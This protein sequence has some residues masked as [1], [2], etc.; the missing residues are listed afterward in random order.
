MSDLQQKV[1]SKVSERKISE[2]EKSIEE[3]Q[4]KLTV[5]QNRLRTSENEAKKNVIFFQK[6]K[7]ETD[8]M[9]AIYSFLILF[10]SLET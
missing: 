9:K 2:Y 5:C 8:D 7:E 10:K 6:F 4:N 1:S 3:L